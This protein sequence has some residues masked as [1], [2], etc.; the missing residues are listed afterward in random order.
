MTDSKSINKDVNAPKPGGGEQSRSRDEDGQIRK[1][2]K[3][4]ENPRI[5]SQERP[6]SVNSRRSPGLTFPEPT[7]TTFDY[8]DTC[9]QG[10]FKDMGQLDNFHQSE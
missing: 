9:T 7:L 2:V 6:T 4:L 8:D 3:M 5:S 1:N 10:D